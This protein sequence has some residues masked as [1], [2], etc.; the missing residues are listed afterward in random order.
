MRVLI[1]FMALIAITSSQ[2]DEGPPLTGS[3]RGFNGNNMMSS[4]AGIAK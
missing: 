1:L 3:P 2:I 4:T